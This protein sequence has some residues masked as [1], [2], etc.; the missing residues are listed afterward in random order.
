MI[1]FQD[2]ILEIP[3]KEHMRYFYYVGIAKEHALHLMA[4]GG[5]SSKRNML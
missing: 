3:L 2:Q 5:G 4:E 1:Y